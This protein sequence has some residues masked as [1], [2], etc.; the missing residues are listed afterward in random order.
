MPDVPRQRAPSN[1]DVGKGEG[2]IFGAEAAQRGCGRADGFA[3]SRRVEFPGV[4]QSHEQDA[5]GRDAG[6]RMQ[7]QRGAGPSAQV[8]VP[9]D[10]R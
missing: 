8:A 9:E 10:F 2:R 3:E 4:A 1:L 7:Q 6:N 5:L